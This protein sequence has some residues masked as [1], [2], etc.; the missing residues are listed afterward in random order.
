MK[1]F[2]NVFYL[3]G[4]EWGSNWCRYFDTNL[5]K[6]LTEKI[7]CGPDFFVEDPSGLYSYF[8]D[9]K[10]KLSKT[11]KRPENG[12]GGCQATL[13]HIRNNYWDFNGSKYNI[14][15]SIFYLDIETTAHSSVNVELCSERIVSIQIFHNLTNTNIILGTEDFDIAKHTSQNGNYIFGDR[16]YDFVCRYIKCSS[17]AELLESYF[18]LVKALTPLFVIAHNGEG[19]DF[20]Y[21]WSRTEKLGIQEH[22]SPYGSSE[23]KT[24]EMNNGKVYYGIDAPGVYYMDSLD[25]YKRFRLSPRSS[26]SLDALAEVELGENKVNHDCFSTFDGFR[27]GTG[28]IRPLKEPLVDSELEYALY[29]AKTDDEIKAISKEWFIHYSIID[30]WLLYKIDAKLR[31][32]KILIKL[33][34]IAGIPMKN[35]IGTIQP[36]EN[37]IRNYCMSKMVVLP[38]PKDSHSDN[39]V[40]GGFVKDPIP[41]KYEWV[42]S[43]DVTSMYPSQMMA[44]NMSPE[45]FVWPKDIPE[46]LRNEIENLKLSSDEQ[47]HLKEYF[48]NKAKY[49]KF[50][51]FLK[52]YNFSSALNGAI[53]RKD[54]RGVIPVLVENV[55]TQ[56]KAAKKKMLEFEKLFESSRDPKHEESA[57]ELDIEQNALKIMINGLYGA[58]GNVHFLLFNEA[59]ANAITG[60]SRFYVQLFSKNIELLKNNNCYYNDTDSGY[61]GIPQNII[62]S[63][64]DLDT[65]SKIDFIDKYIETE[66]QPVVNDSSKELGDIFNAIDPSKISAK[67]EVIAEK[68]ILVAKKRYIMKI[69][70]SEGIRF[71]E[72]HLKTM[73]IDLVRSS[74]PVFS[75]KYLKKSI[76]I[77]LDKTQTELKEFI[78]SIKT[79]FINANLL[80]IGKV[81]SVSKLSYDLKNDKSIPI[82]A[83]AAIVTNN[84]IKQNCQ[85]QF[86]PIQSGE[87]C[88]MLYLR[89]PNP[90][91][92]NIFA[93]D[94]EN[95][96]QKF[97][98][99][100]DW[101]TNF[102]KFFIIPLEI[103]TDPLKYNLRNHTESL[104]VW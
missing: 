28:Y 98:D 72:P 64:K 63:I 90:L 22:F 60:N 46:D 94:N 95:F 56:R 18:K 53:F 43:L 67:R 57:I 30:T 87:K 81:S 9:P 80:D 16:E 100:I 2:E 27:T 36:W 79:K 20:K 26:Y 48:N 7:T 66:I 97:R 40:V 15:P 102:E 76:D 50:T 58:L 93:F 41:G 19:F 3:K 92:S 88:K 1:L 37:Y 14:N 34:S 70:D 33:S 73:G 29:H 103:M 77:I 4:G 75:K 82:N 78:N 10:I 68:A 49:S 54:F 17:E 96:A 25:I 32:T 86:N 42:Y 45:T 21:L 71:K 62:D 8:L 89:T 24:T 83:R 55:F 38:N 11:K 85:G 65:N 5:N 52:K 99:Y 74:T 31:L 39:P 69:W 101:D 51:E 13:V 6:S 23:L 35:A 91:G 61:F 44:F 104:D 59:I 12:Y 84:Y 47:F